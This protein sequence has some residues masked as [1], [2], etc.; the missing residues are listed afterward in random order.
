MASAG[1]GSAVAD[2]TVAT[3]SGLAN[4]DGALVAAAG[5]GAADNP[6]PVCG[7]VAV[8][9]S[10]GVAGAVAIS[11]GTEGSAM[12]GAGRRVMIVFSGTVVTATIAAS[13]PAG[14]TF[15]VVPGDGGAV[16][17]AGVPLAGAGTVI[18]VFGS[19]VASATGVDGTATGWRA[20]WRVIGWET[21]GA[22][23]ES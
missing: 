15:A 7:G 5:F 6:G 2:E 21:C 23:A 17:G 10:F 9:F 13:V 16:T 22:T 4:V 18:A 3:A 20:G 12:A 19:A 11:G 8:D 1:I 14:G